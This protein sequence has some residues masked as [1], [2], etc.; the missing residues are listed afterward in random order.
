[1]VP[2]KYF[3][4][5]VKQKVS[6]KIFLLP[7]TRKKFW[8]KPLIPTIRAEGLIGTIWNFFPFLGA[9]KERRKKNMEVDFILRNHAEFR[10]K[11]IGPLNIPS[12]YERFRR[13]F[14]TLFFVRESIEG[15][16]HIIHDHF[17]LYR[18]RRSSVRG[19]EKFYEYYRVKIFREWC[20]KVFPIFLKPRK[21]SFETRQISQ[22]SLL[23]RC[24]TPS[25]KRV[26]YHTW[27][28]FAPEC[29]TF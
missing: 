1:M 6:H 29:D 15:S 9:R 24:D 20:A 21:T 8:K 14:T 13:K 5:V 25:S 7:L 26:F 28:W 19:R 10:R 12:R 27:K 11:S 16:V 23:T 3:W 18:A 2:M 22:F 4:H 17:F